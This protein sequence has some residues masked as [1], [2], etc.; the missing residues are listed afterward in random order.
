MT[1]FTLNIMFFDMDNLYKKFG[2]RD[3]SD[4]SRIVDY[5]LLTYIWWLFFCFSMESKTENKLDNRKT[6][7]IFEISLPNFLC[8]LS[9]SENSRILK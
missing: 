9:T 2:R 4:I 8:K 5:F 1:I 6:S 7:T 3:G